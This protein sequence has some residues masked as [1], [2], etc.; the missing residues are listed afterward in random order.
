MPL[1]DAAYT[2]PIEICHNMAPIQPGAGSAIVFHT[3]RGEN[4]VTAGCTTVTR[5]T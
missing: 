2:Y 4:R 3:L 1:G 5:I